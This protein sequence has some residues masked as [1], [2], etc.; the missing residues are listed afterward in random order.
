MNGQCNGIC[1]KYK[2]PKRELSESVG[3]C[4]TCR[5]YLK[6]AM[7]RCM[8]C[9]LQLRRNPR[10]SGKYRKKRNNSKPRI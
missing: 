7:L 3:Y 2:T 8:C 6:W 1:E 10:N 9:N 5:K 4:R